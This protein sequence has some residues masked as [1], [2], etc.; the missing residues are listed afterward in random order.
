MAKWPISKVFSIVMFLA[1]MVVFFIWMIGQV[2]D[3]A[4]FFGFRTSHT[5]ANDIASIITS[6]SGVPGDITYN[7][8]LRSGGSGDSE[9]GIKYDILIGDKIVCVSSYVGTD[10]SSTTDC[11]GHPYK[12][13]EQSYKGVSD[14]CIMFEKKIVK[15]EAGS[16]SQVTAGEC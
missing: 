4:F 10:A 15:T 1:M 9:T 7:Y 11:A 6:L 5:V 2:S 8:N 12:I 3:L 13:T 14:K 16:E